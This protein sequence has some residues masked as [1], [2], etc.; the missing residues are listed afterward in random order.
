MGS[1]F[2][3]KVKDKQMN[4][5][6][7]QTSS[8]D[9]NWAIRKYNIAP[10]FLSSPYLKPIGFSEP[11]KRKQKSKE[12]SLQSKKSTRQRQTESDVESV[13][14]FR[15]QRSL[16]SQKSYQSH[17]SRSSTKIYKLLLPREIDKL[18][19][20]FR[21]KH[22]IQHPILKNQTEEKSDDDTSTICSEFA[23]SLDDKAVYL[24]CHKDPDVENALFPGGPLFAEMT[25]RNATKEKEKEPVVK[26]PPIRLVRHE[27]AS[28]DVSDLDSLH[29]GP[30]Q[31]RKG[32]R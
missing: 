1:P 14:S 13:V 17:R 16:A 4:V 7:Q 19:R 8:S 28:G 10:E 3:L 11:E 31:G 27:K 22:N 25:F 23:E 29:S 2:Q 26:L 18:C 15:T 12:S 6:Q 21:Q 24:H 30:G 5:L 20:E 32:R 9:V